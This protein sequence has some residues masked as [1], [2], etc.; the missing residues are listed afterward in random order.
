M[1]TI[2]RHI[3]YTMFP[4]SLYLLCSGLI[5]IVHELPIVGC[6]ATIK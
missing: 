4:I 6:L 1:S 2:I 3:F 5:L